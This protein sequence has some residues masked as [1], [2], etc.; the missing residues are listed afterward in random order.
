MPLGTSLT[1]GV[2]RTFPSFFSETSSAT[3][4]TLKKEARR[5]YSA[6]MPSC[7]HGSQPPAGVQ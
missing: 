1:P 7:L 3:R 6:F 5:S 2:T 4:G